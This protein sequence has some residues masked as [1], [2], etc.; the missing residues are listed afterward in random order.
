MRGEASKSVSVG[1]SPKK[2][3]KERKEDPKD[4]TIYYLCLST[5]LNGK[6][7]WEDRRKMASPKGGPGSPLR[8]SC[9]PCG[10][11][12]TWPLNSWVAVGLEGCSQPHSFVLHHHH[13]PLPAPPPQQTSAISR[14]QLLESRL[15]LA[16]TPPCLRCH[17]APLWGKGKLQSDMGW[18]ET[19]SGRTAALLCP[20]EHTLLFLVLTGPF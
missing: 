1:L 9:H 18:G 13:I 6:D 14:S 11:W 4:G 15:T 20:W 17:W 10:S 3:K 12:S 5:V 19:L 7:K 2:C 16:T 8:L